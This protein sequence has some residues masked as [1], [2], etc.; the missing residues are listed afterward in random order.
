M[1]VW[2]L[3]RNAPSSLITQ[4][5]T[6]LALA[7]EAFLTGTAMELAAVTRIGPHAY[8]PGR[9]TEMLIGAYSDVVRRIPAAVSLRQ[10]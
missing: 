8:N 4:F 2:W 3:L 9:L 10:A 5:A 6:D 7:S 1:S